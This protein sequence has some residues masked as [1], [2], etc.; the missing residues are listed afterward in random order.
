MS[1]VEEPAVL[2]QKSDESEEQTK[3]IFELI[4]QKKTNDVIRM[5]KN[6]Q[7]PF[8]C[9]D[10]NGMTLLDQ[11]CW[12][13]DEKLAKFLLSNGADPNSNKHESG[14]RSLM[15]AAISGHQEICRLLLDHGAYA[16]STNSIG[17][18]AAEM[19]AFVGQHECVSIINNY[20]TLD[21]IERLLHPKGENSDEIYPKKFSLALHGL[22][23]THVFHPIWIILFLRD[24]YETIWPHRKKFVYVLDRVFERQ[25]RCKQSNEAM[26]LKLWLILYTVRETCKL[27]E[28][29]LLENELRDGQILI[30]NYA[31]QLLRM[32]RSDRVRPGLEHFLRNAVQA[33]PYHHCMLFQALVRNL[34]QIEFGNPP[35]AF[36]VIMQ[37]LSGPRFVETSHFCATCGTVNQTK[38]CCQKIYYCHSNC[39]KMDWSNH[40]MFCEKITKSAMMCRSNSSSTVV[41]NELES[42]L[43]RNN[44]NQ[45]ISDKQSNNQTVTELADVKL[46]T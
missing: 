45:R 6:K 41:P 15:F 3:E 38:H 30:K 17:K 21:E 40:K 10:K 20:I 23:K 32:E 11:A 28:T 36:Y 18:T 19:A 24:H 4:R 33:F 13:G 44:S 26:S 42:A 46:N 14:Y 35:A 2:L 37:A 22:I 12:A 9:T 5:L 34:A 39:Q 16:H 29:A 27:V 1:S 31:K 25:L 8:D 7:I 43:H